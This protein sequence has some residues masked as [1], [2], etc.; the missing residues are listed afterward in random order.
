MTC[1]EW[2]SAPTALEV[3]VHAE[4]HQLGTRPWTPDHSDWRHAPKVAV[5]LWLC[6]QRDDSHG[7]KFREGFGW[8][9]REYEPHL[10]PLGAHD[11]RVWLGVSQL[12]VALRDCRWWESAEF[13]P[14]DHDGM[15]VAWP[16]VKEDGS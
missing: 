12:T 13:R 15:P 3:M 11:G 2:R 8:R 4:N 9:S 1:N 14:L 10:Y 6:R 16:S 5:G 7:Q